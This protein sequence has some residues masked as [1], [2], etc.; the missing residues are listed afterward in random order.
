MTGTTVIIILTVLASL[1]TTALY[2]LDKRILQYKNIPYIKRQIIFGVFFGLVAIAGTE[3]GVSVNGA[4]M[5]IRDAGPV[6]AGLFFG[7]EAGVIAG[8][9]GGIERWLCVYW[10]GGEFSRLACTLGTIFAGLLA[11]FIKKYLLEGKLPGMFYA[12]SVGCVA[13]VFHMLML[14]LA[15]SDQAIQAHE[16]I[17]VC[18]PVMIPL[19]AIAAALPAY[20]ISVLNQD[21]RIIVSKSERG[22][23]QNIAVGLLISVIL[24]FVV[25]IAFEYTLQSRLA[26]NSAGVTMSQTLNDVQRDLDEQNL[27]KHELVSAVDK[28][29]THRHIGTVGYMVALD[30]QGHIIA[31]TTNANRKSDYVNEMKDI[32]SVE[33][34]TATKIIDPSG[35]SQNDFYYSYIKYDDLYIVGVYPAVEAELNKSMSVSLTALLEVVILAVVFFMMYFLV[36]V[37]VV[38]ELNTINKDLAAITSG[39]LDTVVDVKSSAEFASLSNDINTTVDALKGYIEEA[40]ARVDEELKVAK[41]IQRSA[42]PN[43]YP[44]D[45]RFELYASMLAAKD[46]GGDFYDFYPVGDDKYAFLIADVSGKGIPAAMFMMSAK[47]VIKSIV[48]TGA[49]PGVAFTKANEKLC[50]DND[51]EM[52]V[53]AW[54][55]IMDIETGHVEYANA[56]HNPPV[57][58]HSDGTFEYLK[59]RPGFVLAGMEG[60]KY[61][62]FEIDLEEGMS[63]FLYTDGVTEATNANTELFGEDRLIDALVGSGTMNMRYTCKYV[64]AQVD[65]FVGDAPQFDDIT[66]LGI[67]RK[68]KEDKESTLVLPVSDESPEQVRNFFDAFIDKNEISMKTS[69]KIMVIVDEIYS[70]IMNYSGASSTVVTVKYGDGKVIMSFQDNGIYYNPLAKE[71]PDVTLSAEER[72]IGGLGIYMV[73]N[74]AEDVKYTRIAGKNILDI[75]L[76]E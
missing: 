15:R 13:E 54:L 52:F 38:K 11:A 73:K 41:N 48:E 25:T 8:L 70:N 66:M 28:E 5:N 67:K 58:K 63:L 68:T 10:G 32:I 12:L 72:N 3:F 19:V 22:I 9:I 21:N 33:E 39:K 53:T 71:D 36:R 46:V 18:A 74:M 65:Q 55:G 62:D 43:V 31:N 20:L 50:A 27:N 42:L 61:K 26:L 37:V 6:C 59:C 16:V 57:L 76:K 14:Y 44:D 1:V 4:I 40:A 56:G 45:N 2:Y 51:A 29:I 34:L 24:A 35:N 64:K 60:I 69:T 49:S 17:S 30:E 47:S 23:A 75:V 7:P